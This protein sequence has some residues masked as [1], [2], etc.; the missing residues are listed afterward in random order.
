MN[1]KTKALQEFIDWHLEKAFEEVRQEFGYVPTNVSINLVAEQEDA[2]HQPA[3]HYTGCSVTLDAV[4]GSRA[5]LHT[6]HIPD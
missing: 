3:H 2:E 6:P 4:P 5:S 1:N